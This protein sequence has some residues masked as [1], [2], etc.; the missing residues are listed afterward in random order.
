MHVSNVILANKYWK[1]MV[2]IEV[3]IDHFC[4]THLIDLLAMNCLSQSI[5]LGRKFRNTAPQQCVAMT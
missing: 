2:D 4:T 5:A 3:Y 1:Q